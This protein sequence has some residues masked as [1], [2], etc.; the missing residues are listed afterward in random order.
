V[1]EVSRSR[2][3]RVEV[4]CKPAVAK[5]CEELTPFLFEATIELDQASPFAHRGLTLRALQV[6]SA[7]AV[8][9]A[10]SL[11]LHGTFEGPIDLSHENVDVIQVAKEILQLLGSLHDQLCL[12]GIRSNRLD[13]VA[14]PLGHDTGFVEPLGVLHAHNLSEIHQE[15]SSVGL[16]LICQGSPKAHMG[17]LGEK[18]LL[19]P[20]DS[21]T[22]SELFCGSPEARP[23]LGVERLGALAAA[24]EHDGGQPV[25]PREILGRELAL[26]LREPF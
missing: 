23:Q 18:V 2:D 9:Q 25:E 4:T 21:E 15:V 1:G 24:L 7:Q 8:S 20:H 26:L 16:D 3:Q 11:L 5:R 17:L 10:N 6:R 19:A 12:A 22:F 14:K 13:E